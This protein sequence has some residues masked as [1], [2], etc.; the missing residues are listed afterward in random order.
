MLQTVVL[1]SCTSTKEEE[2]YEAFSDKGEDGSSEQL[3]E[4]NCND[5]EMVVETARCSGDL[6]QGTDL[7]ENI[8]GLSEKGA[9]SSL[10][11]QVELKVSE[12]EMGDLSN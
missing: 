3:K 12:P 2:N 5:D 4:S 10:A 11:L 6:P 1:P 7:E 8:Q 9:A